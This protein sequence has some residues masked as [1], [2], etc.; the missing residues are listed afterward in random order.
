MMLKL[1]ASK[2]G[3]HDCTA[4]ASDATKI[5]KRESATSKSK[6]YLL[7]LQLATVS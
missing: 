4:F 5:Q 2:V 7:L 6:H 3:D 1:K